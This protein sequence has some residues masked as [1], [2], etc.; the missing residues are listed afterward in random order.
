MFG[1]S[2]LLSTFSALI[3]SM[4]I[5]SANAQCTNGACNAANAI[6]KEC[7]YRFTALKDFKLCLCTNKFLVNYD[8]CARGYV[9][10]WDGNPDTLNGACIALYCPGGFAGGFDAKAFCAGTSTTP[11]ASSTASAR[12]SKT[13]SES[14]IFTAGPVE[15]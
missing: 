12:P 13:F 7:K 15:P 2:V 9:C 4:T 5:N 6:Y 10:A 3:I 14:I 11:A 1:R 8:R